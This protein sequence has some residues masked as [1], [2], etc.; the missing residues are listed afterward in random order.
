MHR[1]L[2]ALLACSACWPSS[3]PDVSVATQWAKTLQKLLA[4]QKT[5]SDL[6]Q[7][8][9]Q[10]QT[11]GSFGDTR[12]N[13]S[14]DELI[15]GNAGPNK[16]SL[17]GIPRKRL[18]VPE[19]LKLSGADECFAFD[20]HAQPGNYPAASYQCIFWLDVQ[21]D[22]EA[23]KD[24]VRLVRLVEQATRRSA[25]VPGAYRSENLELRRVFIG[26]VEVIGSWSSSRWTE[27]HANYVSVFIPAQS[28]DADATSTP[29][30]QRY[31]PMPAAQLLGS[32]GVGPAS[33]EVANDTAY[34]LTLSYEGDSRKTVTISAGETAMVTLP[35]GSFRV[36]ERV[37]AANV[38]PF[39]G[40]VT[41]GPGDRL[42]QR[43]HIR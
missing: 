29:E 12:S 6:K 18:S 43:F 8:T 37:S 22:E 4:M 26:G 31:A 23:R 1:C 36:S 40:S 10:G 21:S 9:S 7:N 24:Y 17:P 15:S 41:F 39:V 35:A 19:G 25:Q 32:S 28:S 16:L 30:G 38:L 2:I 42:S 3:V 14:D 20:R 11:K 13:V 34:T 33:I 5:G 27:G